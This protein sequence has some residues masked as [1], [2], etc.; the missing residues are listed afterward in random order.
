MH[1]LAG[2]VFCCSG[3]FVYQYI[4]YQE[5][6]LPANRGAAAKG[7]AKASNSPRALEAVP[8]K[9][10]SCLLQRSKADVLHEMKRL[11][12]ELDDLDDRI[13]R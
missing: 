5:A 13:T 3:V 10:S 1:Q 11:E 7:S 2:Y 8:S 12:S 4:K 6:K 9:D